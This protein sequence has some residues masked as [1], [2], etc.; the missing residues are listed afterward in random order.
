MDG[1]EQ[2]SIKCGEQPQIPCSPGFLRTCRS[3]QGGPYILL[4]LI[5]CHS[6]PVPLQFS[7]RPSFGD[8]SPGVS[9]ISVVAVIQ[10]NRE[11]GGIRCP[12]SL[13][14][15]LVGLHRATIDHLTPLYRCREGKTRTQ[16]AI[17][18]RMLGQR[19]VLADIPD[20]V[21]SNTGQYDRYP[22]CFARLSHGSFGGFLRAKWTNHV[23]S[24]ICLK[25]MLQILLGDWLREGLDNVNSTKR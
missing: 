17:W 16:P 20:W 13:K 25:Q 8:P 23:K 15:T 7:I 4:S 12:R 22:S 19:R 11:P 1:A 24:W 9:H 3:I 2:M 10:R 18:N 6:L 14:D 5:A 21:A